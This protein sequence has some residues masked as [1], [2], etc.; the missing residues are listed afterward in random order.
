MIYTKN[1]IAMLFLTKYLKWLEV[2][3]L[4]LGTWLGFACI[5]LRVESRLEGNNLKLTWDLERNDLVPPLLH[6]LTKTENKW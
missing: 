5:Y 2:W 6:T 1:E 3:S 4:R